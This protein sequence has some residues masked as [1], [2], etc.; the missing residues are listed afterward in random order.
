M[1]KLKYEH[2][3]AIMQMKQEGYAVMVF[4]PETLGV[5]DPRHFEHSFLNVALK[6]L[7]ISNGDKDEA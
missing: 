5:V 7:S 3:K 1:D 4:S 6:L 2:R